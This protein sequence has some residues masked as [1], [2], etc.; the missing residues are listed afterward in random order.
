MKDPL[1]PSFAQSSTRDSSNVKVVPQTNRDSPQLIAKHGRGF[2]LMADAPELASLEPEVYEEAAVEHRGPLTREDIPIGSPLLWRIVDRGGALLL[3]VGAI[4]PTAADRDFLFDEFEPRRDDDVDGFSALSERHEDSASAVAV[5]LSEMGLKIGSRLGIR[6]SLAGPQATYASKLIGVAPNEL[7]FI[8]PPVASTGRLTLHARDTVQ[9]LAVSALAV[10]LLTCTVEAVGMT[11]SP[12]A[13]LSKPRV[14]RQLRERRAERIKTRIPVI[15]SNGQQPS[16]SISGLGIATDVS[17]LG[18]A[19]VTPTELGQTGDK[20]NVRF[21][22]DM[23]ASTVCIESRGE[24]RNV[25]PPIPGDA[26]E[27]AGSE[28]GIEFAD[29]PQ[30]GRMALRNFVLSHRSM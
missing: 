1:I 4:I 17:D 21:Y 2:R 26:D 3:D 5:S 29:L 25:K 15:F 6:S 20:I 23:H 7:I 27:R 13:I 9:V 14:I 22:L 11:P 28:Y 19:L 8:T 10:Y 24:I 18:M 16:A 30:E 12:Y